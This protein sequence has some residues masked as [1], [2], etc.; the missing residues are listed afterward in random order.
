MATKIK[1][2]KDSLNFN[3][4]FHCN[5][6]NYEAACD[7]SVDMLDGTYVAD[8]VHADAVGALFIL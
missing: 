2:S 6:T 3:A 1:K 5:E 8:T 4:L 7:C